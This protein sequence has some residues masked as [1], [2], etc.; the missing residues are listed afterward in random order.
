M[1]DTDTGQSVI[2]DIVLAACV[3]STSSSSLT[4]VVKM[5]SEAFKPEEVK[6]SLNF[7]VA[8]VSYD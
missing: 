7:F 8:N 6:E 3:L 4:R 5:L 1:P 2:E